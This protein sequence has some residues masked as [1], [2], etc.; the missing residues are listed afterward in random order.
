[1]QSWPA[2]LLLTCTMVTLIY[3]SVLLLH[4]QPLIFPYQVSRL[5]KFT[6]ATAVY[7]LLAPSWIGT[8]NAVLMMLVVPYKSW[9]LGDEYD[10]EGG[11]EETSGDSEDGI[12][13][14][15]QWAYFKS[16]TQIQVMR[17]QHSCLEHQS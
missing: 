13:R 3:L 8:A 12:H 17:G 2:M 15:F 7:L 10:E 16:S 4:P 11:V 5:L 14:L 1:M 6:T 9:K